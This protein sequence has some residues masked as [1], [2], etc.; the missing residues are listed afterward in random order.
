[1]ESILKSN[2]NLQQQT[3]KIV[4]GNLDIEHFNLSVTLTIFIR[5]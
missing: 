4:R 2:D 5:N 1:M 3:E